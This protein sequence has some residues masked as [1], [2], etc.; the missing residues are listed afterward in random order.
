MTSM[1][2]TA[3][4]KLKKEYLFSAVYRYIRAQIKKT[5]TEKTRESAKKQGINKQEPDSD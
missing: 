5:V 2:M 4:L 1:A 3:I